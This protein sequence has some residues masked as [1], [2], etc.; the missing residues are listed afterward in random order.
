MSSRLFL[1][2]VR[3]LAFIGFLVLWGVV[4][5]SDWTKQ[6]IFHRFLGW[7]MAGAALGYLLLFGNSILGAMGKV[8]TFH[9][10]P[11]Y[12]ECGRQV[13]LCGMAGMLLWQ[14]RVWPAGDAKLFMLLALLAP[15]LFGETLP[16]G[17][18]IFFSTLIN[19]FLPA[20]LALFFRAG[21]YFFDTRMRHQL[22]FLKNLGWRREAG[23]FLERW[24]EILVGLPAAIKAAGSGLASPREALGLV[25]QWLSGMATMALLSYQVREY[26]HSP[27]LLSLLCVGLFYLWGM[28]GSRL[29][30]FSQF[31]PLAALAGLVAFEP[32]PEWGRIISLFGSVSI[33][34][35]FT[36]LGMNWAMKVLS[37]GQTGIAFLLPLVFPFFFMG[38]GWIWNGTLR[39]IG[40]FFREAGNL[41]RVSAGPALSPLGA[42]RF[43]QAPALPKGAVPAEFMPLADLAMPM[44]LMCLFFGLSLILVRKWDEEVRPSHEREALASYLTLA[45]EFLDKLRQDKEFFERHFSS[46][47]ADGL[48][49]EQ[50]EAL[51]A[52]CQ[53]KGVDVIPLAPTVSFAAWIFL[54]YFLTVVLRGGTVLRFLL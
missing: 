40:S 33:F 3:G 49:A 4:G 50:A 14:L 32:A 15:L 5:W 23:F 12:L 31:I 43:P 20:C 11:Y 42:W 51:K 53:A 24:R 6:R 54:G 28:V 27:I 18:P 41:V 9:L 46:V 21:W 47:Y 16:P 26:I 39:L 35:F 52:W 38:I 48:T 22:N 36:F 2:G 44:A 8:D 19:I 37:G 25:F 34:S 10:V 45:P 1:H 7:G 17:E 29:G 13:L 30:R